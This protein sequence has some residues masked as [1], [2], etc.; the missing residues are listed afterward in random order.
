MAKS[1]KAFEQE[2]LDHVV[3]KI[4]VAED[5]Q[6]QTIARS[7]KDQADIKT[8][9][10]NDVNIKTD[11][12]EGMMETGL[13][14]RQ[15]QQMLDERQNS[16]QHATKQLSTLKKLEKNA[17][18]ARLDFHEA[19]EPKT[20]TI[21][22]GLSSFSDTPDHFLIY[23]WRAPISSIYY[24]GGLGNV[25]YQTPDGPQSVNVKLKRQL[26]I[27]DGQIVTVYDTDEAVGDSM[28]LEVLDEKSD[29]KMKSI[30]TT[31]QKEQNTII[32]DT[33]SDLLF[34][35]GAAGSGKTSSVLQR[36]AYLLYR[37]RGNLTAG[38]V[39]LFSPNQLFNDYINQVLPELGEQNMVQMTYYQYAS[40]RLPRMKVETLQQRFETENTPAMAKITKLEGS[41]AFFKAVTT[42]GAHLEQADMRFR[43]ITLND[44]VI[45]PR[46]KIKEIYYSFNENYHLGNRLSATKESLI[47]ILNRKVESEMRTKWVEETVQDLSREEI[48]QFYGNQPREFKNGDQE[49]KFLARKIVMQ[50]LGKAR[51]QIVRNRFLSINLQYAHFL[52][53]VP[54]ILNLDKYGITKDEWAAAVDQKLESI[55]ER[56]ISL[57][58]VSAYMYLHDLMTGKKGQ[59]DIRFVFLDEIQDYNAFQLAFLKFSFPN[60]RFTMLGDLNQ[61][62]FT[63]ENSHTLIG[64]LETLFD[65]EKTRVVQLTKSYRST[66]QITDFTKEILVNGEAVTAF[67]RQGDLPNVAVTPD[68][69]TA[70][71]QVVDQLAMN[72]SDRDTTAIIGKTLAECERLTDALQARGEKVTLIRTEN[73]R[74][75]PGVIV[76]PSFLAKGLEFDAVIVWNAN[77]DNYHQEDE[78]QLLYTICS[79]AMHELTI[80]AVGELSPLLSRI[81]PELYTINKTTV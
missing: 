18:F 23:D 65:P 72:D 35:Q 78:R 46:E 74:L 29:V 62:I 1:I 52:R 27:E 25:T 2:H 7:E 32:R 3:A 50:R 42:Y 79:R 31:I 73:Q 20:E 34:V 77:A 6:S 43:N 38:Q 76:V 36:V 45:I 57:T 37:Y 11:S 66:Q 28:L 15:Q 71:D 30:V 60:A 13:S 75:A 64:E 21:Y 39:I 9:F 80:V 5:Q 56:H 69:E 70:V 59:R 26:M 68:F 12:Y 67:D 51:T 49:F 40:Y 19:G 44:E 22:I 63:K 41:L 54:K 55:K 8:N 47:K 33:S 14:V 17:Y 16:W 4:K 24:D 58:T 48:N 81:K 53:E 10:Y 61:A